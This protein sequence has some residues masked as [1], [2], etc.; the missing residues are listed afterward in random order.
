[1]IECIINYEMT[2]T[3][4]IE[5]G[6]V[7]VF[8]TRSVEVGSRECSCVKGGPKDGLAF[9]ICPLMDYPIVDVDVTDVFGNA[10]PLIWTNEGER[11]VTGIARIV[12]HPLAPWMV[13]VSFI[14]GLSRG[15]SHSCW[16]SGTAEES[17]WGSINRFFIF[18]LHIWI[19]NVGKDRDVM[20]V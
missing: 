11:V 1:M 9:A 17:G 6:V 19:N 20:E 15:M 13:S 10:W 14:L 8:D 12:A 5:D 4:G 7:S 18:L 16:I 2:G 3:A